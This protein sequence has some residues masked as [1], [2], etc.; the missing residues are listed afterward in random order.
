MKAAPEPPISLHRARRMARDIL[1]GLLGGKVR[2]LTVLATGRTKIVFHA[3]HNKGGFIVRLGVHPAKIN[4]FLKDPWATEAARNAGVPC[5]EILEVGAALA[6]V[7]YMVARAVRGR[8]AVDH[9]DR[10]KV[11]MEL[12]GIAAV[13]H[14]VRTQGFGSTFDW[15]H[16][17]LTRHASLGSHLREELGARRRL[18][19]LRELKLITTAQE[20]AHAAVLAVLEGYEGPTSLNHGDLRLKNVFL[21]TRGRIEAL[22]DWDSCLAWPA[23]YWDLSICLH[24]LGVDEKEA[25]LHGYGLTPARLAELA[26]VMRL[27]NVINYLP[28]AE[29]ALRRG[30]QVKLEWMAARLRGD[31]DLY[32]P[33]QSPSRRDIPPKSAPD[34]KS[35]IQAG[36]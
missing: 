24:D 35:S 17:R 21:D 2:R 12:G 32:C 20:R 16:N 22:I 29:R 36:A 9:P 28:A 14:G 23:P 8:C 30:D 3:S 26:P 6:P 1:V 19:R 7:P 31:F 18:A 13:L 34:S 10:E 5:P 33:S 25:F 11:L 27:L 4:E 15:S